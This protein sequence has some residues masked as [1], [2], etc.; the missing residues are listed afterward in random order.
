M[1]RIVVLAA[2]VVLSA[3]VATPVFAESTHHVR[4]YHHRNVHAAYHLTGR[5]Y[6]APQTDIANFGFHDRSYPGGED[7]SLNPSSD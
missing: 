4:A 2:V 5:V 6:V 7:P 1:T 3:A